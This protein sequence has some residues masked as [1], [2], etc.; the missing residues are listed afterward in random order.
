GLRA[1][2]KP[3]HWLLVLVMF[4]G[5][6]PVFLATENWLSHIILSRDLHEQQVENERLTNAF[7]SMPD[8]SAF[9][10][11]FFVVAIVPAI[12]EELFFRGVIMRFVK[13]RTHKMAL[14]IILSAAAFAYVHTNI[15]GL[16]S[17]FGA[18]VL[19]ALI[20][21]YTGSILCS[22]F[23]HLINNGLQI[24]IFYLAND[25]ATI[26]SIMSSNALPAYVPIIGA[27]IFSIGL[28]FLWKTR[29]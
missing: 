27:V 14:P 16:P 19:L 8:L 18:G 15:Y 29:T 1:P 11:T 10:K 2:G 9:L 3:I 4:I 12:G 13:M 28:Y 20:Y 6:M 23:G 21:Y 5:I 7:L 17:I 22:M 25:N 24:V 26:K